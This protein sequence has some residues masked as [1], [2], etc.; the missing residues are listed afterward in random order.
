MTDTFLEKYDL[1]YK[2]MFESMLKNFPLSE[3]KIKDA[4]LTN[5]GVQL[6]VYR[7]EILRNSAIAAISAYH[8]VLREKLLSQGIDIGD[9]E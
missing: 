8:D 9:F 1:Y 2:L 5:R 7:D 3:K 6:E 4:Q